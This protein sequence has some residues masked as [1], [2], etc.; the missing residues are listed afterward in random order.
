MKV[1]I[2]ASAKL[3]YPVVDQNA[4]FTKVIG[5]F[6][7]LDYFH[8]ITI[9]GVFVTIGYLFSF[10]YAY[11]NFGGLLMGFFPND[12]EVAHYKK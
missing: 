1:D 3:E 5:N 2:T 6:S 9:T 8:F 11:L 10:M 12:D 7:S 4:Q